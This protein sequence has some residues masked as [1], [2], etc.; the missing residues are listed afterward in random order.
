MICTCLS[1]FKNLKLLINM[2]GQREQ[3]NDVT[4]FIDGSM[5]YGSTEEQMSKL[6]DTHG[7][8]SYVFSLQYHHNII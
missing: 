3:M 1:S 7:G 5:V 6:R 8:M 4:S 2:P